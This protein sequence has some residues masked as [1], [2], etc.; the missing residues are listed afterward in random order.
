MG[1][2]DE[3]TGVDSERM[4]ARYL[5]VRRATE[6]LAAP[7]SAEDQVLQSMPLASPSK[8]HRA[9]TS[10]FFETFLLVPA[11]VPVVNERYGYLYNS[12]YEAVGPR[13][14]RPK[15]GLLSRPSVDEVTSYRRTV[16]GRIVELLRGAA[17]DALSRMAPLVELGLAHEEQHQEL[18]LTD[19]LSAFAEN[20][21]L[22]SY[23]EQAGREPAQI[24]AAPLEFVAFDGGL[25]EIGAKPGGFCFDNETPR[26]KH[27]LEPFL[28]A[29]RPVSVAE[30]AAFAREGGYRTPS[31]WLSEGW[32]FVREHALE[33]PL[34]TRLEG[35]RALVFGLDGEREAHPAEPARHLSHYEADA[36]AR[37]MGARLPT[38]AEWEEA[39]SHAVPA[40]NFVENGALRPLPAAGKRGAVGQLFGDVWEWTQSAYSPYPGYRVAQGALGEYN[41]KFM[42]RQMVLRGGSCLTPSGHVRASYRNFWHPDTRFQMTGVRLAKDGAS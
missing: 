12:Y 20:P 1:R 38:E 30:L 21:L 19:I 34:Y 29:N 36:I 16:D 2:R 4:V 6:T 37:F 24:A 28:L 14:S 13:H 15:R 18:L 26:H 11:G 17:P 3:G 40:G 10:W 32:D 27:W 41:G 42:A 31:L 25:V 33:A 22:P 39:A 7:L 5:E 35:E 9:H 23:L 8:W